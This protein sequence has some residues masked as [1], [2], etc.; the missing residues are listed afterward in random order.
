M[1]SDDISR[2]VRQKM[3]ED[4]FVGVGGV[5]KHLTEKE[6]REAIESMNRA[7]LEYSCE[8]LYSVGMDKDIVMDLGVIFDAMDSYLPEKKRNI[9][10]SNYEDCMLEVYGNL[11]GSI[12]PHLV[13]AERNVPNEEYPRF[14]N[15][16]YF[17]TTIDSSEKENA[18]WLNKFLTKKYC[19]Q[20]KN[21][22]K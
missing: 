4:G 9:F 6:K 14:N 17:I 22:M 2:K 7:I 10:Y 12:I 19:K 13:I 11:L 5:M 16:N 20:E 8:K 15:L 21:T 18:L 3:L 1:N